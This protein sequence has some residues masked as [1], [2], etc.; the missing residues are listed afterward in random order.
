MNSM[1]IFCERCI[2]ARCSVA[3][4]NPNPDSKV[5]PKPDAPE[6]CD[7]QLTFDAVTELRGETIIF[8]DRCRDC[9]GR[10]HMMG[11]A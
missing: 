11:G 8:K 5:K 2:D 9:A 3:G 4:S 7:P 6:R 10:G 1:D